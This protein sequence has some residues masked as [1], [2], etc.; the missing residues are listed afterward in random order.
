MIHERAYDHWASRF[1]LDDLFH[2]ALALDT[3]PFH[4]IAIP[5]EFIPRQA[6]YRDGMPRS[7][8]VAQFRRA[9]T[10]R[11]RYW[12]GRVNSLWPYGWNSMVPGKPVSRFYQ[13]RTTYN[14]PQGSLS[15]DSVA[16][17]ATF[18]DQWLT[19][20]KTEPAGAI[21]EAKCCG[22]LAIH[23]LL[24]HLQ[25]SYTTQQLTH[26]SLSPVVQLIESLRILRADPP[27]R[28]FLKIKYTSNMA[29]D[30]RLREV[31]RLPDVYEQHPE[32]EDAAA[33][34]VT[35]SFTPQV[36]AFLFNYTQAAVE[37]NVDHA[38]HDQLEQCTCHSC[39]RHVLPSDLGPEG[40]VCTYD[41]RRR[42]WGYLADLTI[43]GKKFRLPG[44]PEQSLKELEV[45]L[46]NY[47]N[48]CLE[49]DQGQTRRQK[50]QVWADAV[51]SH[52]LINWKAAEIRRG[53]KIV[54]GFPGLR[55]AIAE[56]RIHLV[57]LHDD[58]A[59][60][61]LFVVCKR[62]YQREMARY[63]SDNSVFEEVSLTWQQT[64]DLPAPLGPGIKAK[65]L[66]FG[67]K[68]GDGV[69]YNYGI[70]KP[71]K[72]KFRFIAGTRAAVQHPFDGS[73]SQ[74]Q[75]PDRKRGP[76]RSPMYFLC[77]DLVR[78]LNVVI[79]SLKEADARNQA[80][81]GLRCFW[82]IDSIN[83]FTRSVRVN[84]DFI[85][86]HGMA[87]YDFST[88]YTA[89][90]LDI[91]VHNVMS[92]VRE[93]MEYEASKAPGNGAPT[94]TVK[95]W[96]WSGDGMDYNTLQ[97]MLHFSVY[98]NFIVN[99]DKLR[100]QVKGIPMGLP[101]APQLVTLACYPVEKSYVLAT[102]P[103]GLACRYIDDFFVSGMTPPPQ[104]DYFM[105]YK[106][107]STDPQ[108]VVYLGVEVLVRGG[109]V[110]TSL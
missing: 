20:W 17:A 85:A 76:P 33:I 41:T 105:E 44:S 27:K 69:Y 56:A 26:N 75:P 6:Y 25:S 35:E 16:D 104:E 79:K 30:F 23:E 67:Y 62:W 91:L 28:H 32:P 77:K 40:H 106:L 5:L 63:L 110:H 47:V 99:G 66:D 3:T 36:Q 2:H 95:G 81:T 65:L 60:H 96:S 71:R 55:Q 29:R 90:P 18:C 45:A 24:H 9:A 48:W 1:R 7:E 51:Y 84:A 61:G 13:R 102:R 98:F 19:R 109:K 92:S 34:M 70:W 50:L 59:P 54:E 58:R 100:R 93:A 74:N 89:F 49:K 4:F 14:L 82:G 11:E 86:S 52:A 38:L 37:L 83:E 46:E 80:E 97:Q 107:T 53:D 64:L 12:V 39:F 103:T 31:L 94:L 57:F 42:K 43:K 108:R 73:S 101:H 10:P 15:A 21:Q 72:L 22:K 88:M 87:T 78:L 8:E 68:C